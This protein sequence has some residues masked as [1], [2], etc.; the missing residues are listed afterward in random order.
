[1]IWY[2]C[3]VRNL[4]MVDTTI[5]LTYVVTVTHSELF[6]ST[7]FGFIQKDIRSNVTVRQQHLIYFCCFAHNLSRECVCV[8][9]RQQMLRRRL[10][11]WYELRMKGGVE[12]QQLVSYGSFGAYPVGSD[13]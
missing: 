11:N 5:A 7:I 10:R 3:L 6:G 8:S 12:L 13:L 1:M 9:M 2:T 4:L